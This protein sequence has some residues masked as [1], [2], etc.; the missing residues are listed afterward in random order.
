MSNATADHRHLLRRQLAEILR[1]VGALSDPA[2]LAAFVD[3]PRDHF[4][5]DF[6]VRTPDG[7]SW[8]SRTDPARLGLVHGDTTLITEVGSDGTPIS[9]STAP[10]LMATMLE[11]LELRGSERVLEIGTGTGYNAALLCHRLGSHRVVTVDIEPGLTLTAAAR[12]DD[13]GYQPTVLTGDGAEG[14]PRHGPFDRLI[15]TCGL[16][17]VPATWL[18]QVRPGGR[19]LVNLGFGLVSLLVLEDGT[20]EGGV[21]DFAAFLPR[22]SGVDDPAPDPHDIPRH[23]GSPARRDTLPEALDDRTGRAVLSLHRP[24]LWRGSHLDDDGRVVHLL[25]E[26][27]TGAWARATELDDGSVEVVQRDGLWDAVT[28]ILG[29]WDERGRPDITEYGIRADARG[30][31]VVAP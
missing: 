24:G 8:I 9:S 15:T 7:L 23:S 19:I 16:T 20:A 31:R 1:A 4:V 17:S 28:A 14:A 12:L 5:G 25:D 3:V 10:S 6:A 2:L 22:R 13:L 21:L 30:H 29:E 18:R 11:A 26:R 27:T